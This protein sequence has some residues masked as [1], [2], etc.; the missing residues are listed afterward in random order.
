[1]ND[2]RPPV[3]CA[4][5]GKHYIVRHK[6]WACS[7]KCAQRLEE[8]KHRFNTSGSPRPEESGDDRSSLLERS[9]AL[10]T[11][12]VLPS[13]AVKPRLCRMYAG[14]RPRTQKTAES[15]ALLPASLV[16]K[17]RRRKP[18]VKARSSFRFWI[19]SVDRSGSKIYKSLIS[20]ALK[21]Q[22]RTGCSSTDQGGGKRRGE[23]ILPGP[24]QRQ[25][26]PSGAYL[27]AL[28]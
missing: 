17:L 15:M 9:G 24:C 26:G 6:G 12:R 13:P 28:P 22:K 27:L 3:K 10:L 19:D 18:R 5:C 1:M 16:M 23:V 8:I 2:A 25:A 4:V 7:K 20:V 14:A 11:A 21:P